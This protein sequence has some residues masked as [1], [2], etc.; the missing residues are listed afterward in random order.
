MEI[1]MKVAM[2][3]AIRETP[4]GNILEPPVL[5]SVAELRKPRNRLLRF[6][7]ARG[8]VVSKLSTNNRLSKGHGGG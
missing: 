8:Q 2:E 5:P 6:K 3:F 1:A 4:T 7:L